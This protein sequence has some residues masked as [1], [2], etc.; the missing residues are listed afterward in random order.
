MTGFKLVGGPAD[1][2]YW[3]PK[4]SKLW[5][6]SVANPQGMVNIH[7][8]Y[9]AVDKTKK[10]DRTAEY[11]AYQAAVKS[12]GKAMENWEYQISEKTLLDAPTA[13]V[14]ADYGLLV[15]PYKFHLTDHTQSGS[16]TIGGYLGYKLGRPGI[17]I[18]W[19]ISA[20]IGVVQA[21]TTQAGSQ[22]TANL[23]SF[24]VATGP[25]V[26]LT[27]AGMFQVGILVGWDYTGKSS[28]YQYEGKPWLALSFGSNLTK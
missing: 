7:F 19:V 10:E 18:S 5:V 9:V 17:A 28:Q 27:K 16:A 8:K 13:G 24:T 14:G 12:D 2:T 1:K 26:Y 6:D 23:A 20:G 22:A 25:I 3:A 4:K 11:A 21:T 15:V